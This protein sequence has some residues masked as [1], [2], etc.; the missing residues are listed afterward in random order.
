MKALVCCALFCALVAP[1]QAENDLQVH[2]STLK[3]GVRFTYLYLP[4]GK[5]FSMFTVAPMGLAADDAGRTQ[6]AHLVEHMVIRT[7][8]P[9]D[10]EHA[11]AETMNDCMHLDYYTTADNWHEALSHHARWLAGLPFDPERLKIEVG[12]ANSEV[13]NTAQN[14]ASHKFAVAAWNQAYRHGRD[15]AAV[16]QDLFDAKP[17]DLQRYRDQH[18]FIPDR[19]V[20]CAIGGAPVKEVESAV[21]DAIGNLKS[22]AKPRAALA[23]LK[24]RDAKVTWDVPSRQLMYTWPIPGPQEPGQY[25]AFLVAGPLLM[26]QASQDAEL[27]TLVGPFVYA[28]ADLIS[29]EGAFFC[30]SATLKPGAPEAAVRSKFDELIKSLLASDELKQAVP[31]VAKQVATRLKPEMLN[32]FLSQA[33]DE[34]QK[35]M[36]EMQFGLMW[37]VNEFHYGARRDA[38]VNALEK[39]TGDAMR[40]V[41]AIHLTP[42][43]RTVLLMV[44]G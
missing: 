39:L 20:V 38:T 34:Q 37:A 19:T 21:G 14:L 2:S 16:K 33:P 23:G 12:R 30:L 35:Y 25:A 32:I 31:L 5:G 28:G 10:L 3:N 7:T 4:D 27:K 6:W 18:L 40:A 15:H 41:A 42:Q 26:S 13:D 11:N 24:P 43:R 29:P 36:A 44:Q 9:G 22:T 8:I 17:A 1:A